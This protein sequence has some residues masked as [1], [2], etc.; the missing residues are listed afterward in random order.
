MSPT[1]N[2]S[3]SLCRY[4]IDAVTSTLVYMSL[5]RVPLPSVSRHQRRHLSSSSLQL[6]S[7]P[8]AHIT[9]IFGKKKPASRRSMGGCH[10]VPLE[11]SP[12]SLT[13]VT[14]PHTPKIEASSGSDTC[15]DQTMTA[16]PSSQVPA[17]GCRPPGEHAILDDGRPWRTTVQRVGRKRRLRYRAAIEN[18]VPS[19]ED[20]EGSSV[21]AVGVLMC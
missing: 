11:L 17:L 20:H 1:T 18:A 5:S 12:A 2:K 9:E 6:P 16:H 8:L 4:P 14:W 7:T 10:L 13:I 19:S 15:T 3:V 21:G